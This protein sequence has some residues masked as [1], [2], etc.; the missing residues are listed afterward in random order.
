MD[1][2]AIIRR[3]QGAEKLLSDPNV[4]QAFGDLEAELV[5]EWASSR[6]DDSSGREAIWR[7][8]KSLELFQTKLESWR[9]NGKLEMA[10]AERDAQDA[11]GIS[12]AA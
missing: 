12:N 4:M 11:R 3:G 6:P 7:Q 9:D 8:V 2:D 1:R 5:T 10:N